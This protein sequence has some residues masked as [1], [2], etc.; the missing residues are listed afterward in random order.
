[1][2]GTLIA[3]PLEGIIDLGAEKGRL[4]KDIAKLSAE[5]EKIDAKLANADFIA[6]AP[7]EVVDEN[8]ERREDCAARVAKLSTA[9]QNLS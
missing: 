4:A 8:R 9:L 7:A 3:L 5:M 1:V 2:R 6:R